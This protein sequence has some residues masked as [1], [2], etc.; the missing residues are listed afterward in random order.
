M[1]IKEENNILCRLKKQRNWDVRNV[2]NMSHM[3]EF[4]ENP[5][6]LDRKLGCESR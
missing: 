2:K 6:E 1:E 3:F 4:C 5:T